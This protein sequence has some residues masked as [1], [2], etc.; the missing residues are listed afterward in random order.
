MGMKTQCLVVVLAVVV[1]IGCSRSFIIYETENGR[2]EIRGKATAEEIVA[3]CGIPDGL[4]WQ[5]RTGSLFSWEMCSAPVYLYGPAAIAF[6]CDGH[7]AMILSSDDGGLL[8]ESLDDVLTSASSGRHVAAALGELRH[9]R[10]SST[11]RDRVLEVAETASHSLDA[12]VR[13]A[14]LKTIVA[15]ESTK[16]NEGKGGDHK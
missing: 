4:H 12:A 13:R 10:L 6:G 16:P 14:A 5:A 8:E 7:P 9:R 2:C 3:T 11:E 15:L 1:T